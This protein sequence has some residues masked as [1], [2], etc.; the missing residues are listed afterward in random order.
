METEEMLDGIKVEIERQY[1]ASLAAIEG[2][3]QRKLD[4]LRELATLFS[5]VKGPVG[6]MSDQGGVRPLV[7]PSRGMG[8]MAMCREAFEAI[9]G[10]VSVATMREKAA[11]LFGADSVDDLSNAMRTYLWHMSKAGKLSKHSVTGQMVNYV[12]VKKSEA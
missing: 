12:K 7:R 4:A 1:R 3:R 6:V 8:K 2:V 10:L 9:D 11:S 5:D